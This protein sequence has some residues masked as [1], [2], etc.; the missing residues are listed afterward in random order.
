MLTPRNQALPR[1]RRLR[2]TELPV[3]AVE[4]A[5]Y[6]IGK[7]LVRE[8]PSGRL[9]GRI[10]EVEAYVP[11]DAAAHS[12]RGQTLANRS[13]F[14]ERGHA[15]VYFAYGSSFM[16]NVSAE[17][18]GVGGGVLIRAL[19]PL[20]GIKLMQRHRGTNKLLDLTRGPG[21]LAGAMKIDKRLNGLDLC[22]RGPLWLGAAVKPAGEV[23]ES[24]RIGITRE[25][26][27]LLRFYERGNPFVSG[28]KRLRL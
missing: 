21:R 3:A 13:L 5:R 2:R 26:H 7:T 1:I 27:R 16:M 23:G 8:L 6:L 11:G 10:V 15:Y 28:P 18:A 17:T 25:V 4:L 19:E 20:E 22:A 12:F 9:S 14:L 24:V